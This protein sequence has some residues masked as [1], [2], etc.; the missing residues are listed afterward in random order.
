MRVRP[1]VF[2]S[3][4][5]LLAAGIGLAGCGAAASPAPPASSA[6]PASTAASAKP[7]ASAPASAA[8]PGSA[9]AKPAASAAAK[10][11]AAAAAGGKPTL[12]VSYTA[13]NSATFAPIWI[14]EDTHAWDKY[15]INVVVTNVDSS[16]MTPTLVGK[17][18]DLFDVSAAP[19]L[20][21]DI[22]GHLDEVYIGSIVSTN[23]A[24]LFAES[25]IKNANDLKGK[26]VGTDKPGTPTDFFV[27]NLLTNLNLKATDVTLRILGGSNI[28]TP[29][30]LSGQ[31]QSAAST[32]PVTFDLQQRGYT[33]LADTYGIPYVANGY[34][35][36]R[37][38]IPELTPV[39]PGFLAGIRDAITTYN[40]QPDVAKRV[41][42]KYAKEDKQDILDKTYD[43]YTRTVKF[44]PSL[45]VQDKALQTMLDY[46]GE[47]I[48]PE[49]KN[50]KPEQFKDLRF[51][52]Q[53]PK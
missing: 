12:K 18:A 52:N 15:G 23:T 27:R 43:F 8:A 14:A 38:R 36:L 39:L 20:T 11:S 33:Q 10:P 13:T 47:T 50:A 1:G 4:A 41:I 44:D 6:P 22:N 24:V 46:L 17:D 19:V 49:A 28:T 7:A 34:V 37:S 9:S 31:I 51:L 45:D 26:Q 21:A 48:I 25:S 35:V 40:T 30:L 53:L 2:R 3:C 16:L 5:W 29:A 32:P 42:S